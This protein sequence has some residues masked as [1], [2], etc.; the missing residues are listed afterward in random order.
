ML[1]GMNTAKRYYVNVLRLK[2]MLLH[3]SGF[4]WFKFQHSLTVIAR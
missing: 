1:L 2:L 4:V 3:L